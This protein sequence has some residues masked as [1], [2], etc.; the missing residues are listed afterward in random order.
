MLFWSPGR[1]GALW[2]PRLEFLFSKQKGRIYGIKQVFLNIWIT[3]FLVFPLFSFLSIWKRKEEQQ[4]REDYLSLLFIEVYSKTSQGKEERG[5]SRIPWFWKLKFQER[6]ETFLVFC[7]SF[8]RKGKEG[9]IIKIK[10][11]F[12]FNLTTGRQWLGL[13]FFRVGTGKKVE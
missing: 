4:E 6:K 7:L 8:Q 3:W 13:P 2:R 12:F 5:N 10:S 9:G 11:S 1:R